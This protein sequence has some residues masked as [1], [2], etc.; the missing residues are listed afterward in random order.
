MDASNVIIDLSDVVI[1]S[2]VVN[3]GNNIMHTDNAIN[4]DAVKHSCHS[5]DTIQGSLTVNSNENYLEIEA[6]NAYERL[7][8]QIN[9][10]CNDEFDFQIDD[11]KYN[12]KSSIN[13][14]LSLVK[15]VTKSE[16]LVIEDKKKSIETILLNNAQSSEFS[17]SSEDS[18][19]NNECFIKKTICSEKN[20]LNNEDE[21]INNE[22]EHKVN[23]EN[24]D[25]RE[26]DKLKLPRNSGSSHLSISDSLVTAEEVVQYMKEYSRPEEYN[27]KIRPVITYSG[28]NAIYH[29]MVGPPKLDQKLI[30]DRDWIFIFA[31]TAFDQN[32]KFHIRILQSVYYGLTKSKINCPRF[33]SHWE[34]IGFQGNDPSTDL[35]GCGMLGL[36]S[37]LDFIQSPATL[38]LASKIYSLSQDLVQN[39]PFCIMSINV[40][41]ISLQ[42][43]R[44][45]KLN[46]LCNS[47]LKEKRNLY[48]ENNDNIVYDTFR[49]LY[50]AIFYKIFS[51]WNNEAKTMADS[52]YVLKD[53][54]D[55][56]KKCPLDIIKLYKGSNKSDFQ[57]NKIDKIENFVGVED[58]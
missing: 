24:E 19:K 17:E 12:F 48:A 56:A 55:S 34:N 33:G 23:E 44:E 45:G 16:L 35:R 42:I 40:T 13:T 51:I 22:N 58:L 57:V 4:S 50:T 21:K 2:D 53:V 46:K 10:G 7:I 39:F 41:R 52:G 9:E 27:K 26:W 18:F 30:K 43:L 20:I 29:W 38:G 14:S 11:H 6:E 25:N 49:E 15:D 31:A 8:Q 37:V 28:I 3:N 32:E 54:E 1:D 36:I 5:D 47:K